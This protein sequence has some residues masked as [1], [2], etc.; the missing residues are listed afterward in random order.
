MVLP[1]G[2]RQSLAQ[3]KPFNQPAAWGLGVGLLLLTIA[4]HQYVSHPEWEANDV[5][6]NSS[7]FGDNASTLPP[8]EQATASEIDHLSL[9]LNQLQPTTSGLTAPSAPS[10]DELSAA[11]QASLALPSSQHSSSPL[12]AESATLD[13]PFANYLARTEFRVRETPANIYR[14]TGTQVR[15]PLGGAQTP[16]VGDT[17]EASADLIRQ[18]QLSPLAEALLQQNNLEPA[19]FRENETSVRGGETTVAD[20]PSTA[21]PEN[22]A[23]HPE[24]VESIRPWLVNNSSPGIGQSFIRTTPQMSPPPGTTGYTLPPGLEPNRPT[25]MPLPRAPQTSSAGSFIDLN[26]SPTAGPNTFSAGTTAPVLPQPS[27]GRSGYVQ[28]QPLPEPAP[29]TVPRPPGSYTGGGYI[30]TFSDPNGPNP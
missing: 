12:G 9:L 18:P 24:L 8:E 26:L 13:T 23:P 5:M 22:P 30:Y 17:A 19:S 21:N 14:P 3:I 25:T 28:P 20:P 29:F 6:V 15:A 2:I 1:P 10:L 16:T 27:T 11:N 7:S 4:G